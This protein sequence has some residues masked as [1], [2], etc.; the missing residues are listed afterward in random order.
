M[1]KAGFKNAVIESGT[2]VSNS[3]IRSLRSELN[4]DPDSSVHSGQL[5]IAGRIV[6][7]RRRI[8][9]GGIIITSYLRLAEDGRRNV[10][11]NALIEAHKFYLETHKDIYGNFFN[12]LDINESFVLVRDYRSRNGS[13]LLHSCKCGAQ[14]ITVAKQRMVAT[15]PICSLESKSMKDDTAD[16]LKDI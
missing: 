6:D 7:N 3:M 14:Y 10:D 8:I 16:I 4:L 5:K 2:G 12:P 15:C 1:I 13:I 11:F 9:D